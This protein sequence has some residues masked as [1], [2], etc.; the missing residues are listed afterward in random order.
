[1][2]ML[3]IIKRASVEAVD[4]GNPVAVFFGVVVAS[5]PLKVLVDQRFT[6]PAEFLIVP[7][8]L[9]EQRVSVGEADV[10]I[11]KGLEVG[12]KLILLRLQGGQQYLIVDRVVST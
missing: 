10:L 9:T 3:D 6:L 4:A 12:H 7:E 1:M 5:A 11:R 8:R 2:S